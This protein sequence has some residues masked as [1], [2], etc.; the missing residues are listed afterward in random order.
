MFFPSLDGLTSGDSAILQRICNQPMPPLT[1]WTRVRVEWLDSRSD[2]H[3]WDRFHKT[4]GFE[5][6]ITPAAGA[7][8]K[9]AGLCRASIHRSYAH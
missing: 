3:L 2:G 5:W 7:P 1:A 8:E 4:Y 6:V 9:L